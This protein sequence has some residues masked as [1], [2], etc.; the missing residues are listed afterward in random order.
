MSTPAI[1][2]LVRQLAAASA[3]LRLFVVVFVFHD[4]ADAA[5]GVESGLMTNELVST[6][7]WLPTRS[8][9]R[10]RTVVVVATG[11]RTMLALPLAAEIHASVGATSA[12]S[13]PARASSSSAV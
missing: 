8:V 12:H 2:S 13:T 11:G 9:A 5:G 3:A 1:G 7:V 6:I 4:S 10:H